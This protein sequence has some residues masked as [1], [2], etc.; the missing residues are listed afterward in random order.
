MEKASRSNRSRVL[1]L[2]RAENCQMSVFDPIASRDSWRPETSF[3][4]R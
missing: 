2:L 4:P 1:I 3:W